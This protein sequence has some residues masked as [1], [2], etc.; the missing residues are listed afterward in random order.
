[1]EKRHLKTLLKLKNN[2]NIKTIYLFDTNQDRIKD[3]D[4]LDSSIKI[5][6]SLNDA[7]VSADTVYICTPTSLHIKVYNEIK[8]LGN[9]NLFSR[10]TIIK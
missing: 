8:N 2:F 10:E 5:C 7:V 9:Y 6:S 1:M 3:L 4:K